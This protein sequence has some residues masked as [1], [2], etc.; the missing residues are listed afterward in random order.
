VVL[1]K[2]ITITNNLIYFQ[3]L[4]PSILLSQGLLIQTSRANLP[5]GYHDWNFITTLFLYQPISVPKRLFA[6]P[7]CAINILSL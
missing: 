2:E 5:I 7:I 1:N 3:N 6:N 4:S